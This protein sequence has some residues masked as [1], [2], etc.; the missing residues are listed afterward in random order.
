MKKAIFFIFSIFAVSNLFAQ[1]NGFNYKAL[2]ANNGS[3][4][5]SQPI[6]I[7]FTILENGTTS[8]YQETQNTSTDANGIVSVNIGEGTVVS[9]NFPHINWAD[10]PHFLKVEIN[11]GSGYQDFGTTEF[12][13]V[14]YAKY[15]ESAEVADYV[16]N[17]FWHQNSNGIN[18]SDRV[19]VGR[20]VSVEANLHINDI[21][22]GEPLIKME[23]A[24]NVY[25]IWQSNR[26]GTDDYLVGIDGGNNNFQISNIT[27][28]AHPFTIKAD[29]VGINN[30]NPSAN[31]DIV[32]NMAL[33][34][35][36]QGDGKVLTSDANGV[37]S[38]QAIPNQSDADFYA[39]GTTTPPTSIND[40]IYHLGI[41]GLGT[42]N[43][44]SNDI[45]TVE[46]IS[47]DNNGHAAIHASMQGTGSGFHYGIYNT[48]G[49]TGTG[50]QFGIY[51]RINNSGDG[52]HYASYSD[53]TGNGIGRHTGTYTRISGSGDGLVYGTHT[54]ITNTGGGTHYGNYIALN[55][56]GTN[57]RQYGQFT[58]VSGNSGTG[59]KYGYYANLYN[60]GTGMGFG[61]YSILGGVTDGNQYG[62]YSNIDASGDG[63]HY[64]SYT[65]LSGTGIGSKYGSR[66]VIA[67]TAGG[68]H[69]AVYGEATKDA[70]NVYAGYFVGDVKVT[71][72]KLL[73]E[74]SGNTD[75]KA[76]IYG[77]IQTSAT[78]AG[79]NT[80]YSSAGFTVQKL[81]GTGKYR[82]S[83]TDTTLANYIVVANRFY[84][85]GFVT[86]RRYTGYF[87]VYVYDTS[88]SFIDSS[89]TF[90]VYKK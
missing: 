41:V 67:P 69:Y 54:M 9:G 7:R 10:N 20:P 8:V 65:F 27:T 50:T 80:S 66:N 13:Y 34:D 83:F 12:K 86:Y 81:A 5:I 88:G 31:F 15:A 68:A 25:T 45:L 74:D 77:Q 48:V 73:G 63:Y 4:L 6:N 26:T 70:N 61:Y 3:V 17:T 59:R 22:S 30:I 33:V 40:E 51:T 76:Y 64:G 58:D 62:L 49:G 89:F 19:G 42:D 85:P 78:T 29:K 46:N 44:N 55:S 2:I 16:I 38:W 71:D 75:M 28:G 56:N 52:N 60:G 32:G 37:A 84:Y 82:I 14:P 18:S 35:G 1:N 79:I 87:D 47:A 11:T 72:G 21:T 24:D 39:V 57:A 23:S 43:P 53:I 36:N 90:V